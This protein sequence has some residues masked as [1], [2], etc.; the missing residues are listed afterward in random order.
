MFLNRSIFTFSNENRKV[1]YHFHTEKKAHHFILIVFS[2]SNLSTHHA[3]T[4]QVCTTQN[5]SKILTAAANK[6][7]C[8]ANDN[9]F[10]SMLNT[11]GNQ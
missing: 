8:L 11:N 5:P 7:P 3:L 10:G 2:L 4:I 6:R 1:Y 9:A